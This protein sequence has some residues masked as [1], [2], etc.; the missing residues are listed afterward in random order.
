MGFSIT[1]SC[2]WVVGKASLPRLTA[3]HVNVSND[4]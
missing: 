4:P 3:M 1:L 2:A